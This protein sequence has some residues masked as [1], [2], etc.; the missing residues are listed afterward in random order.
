MAIFAWVVDILSKLS[1]RATAVHANSHATHARHNMQPLS[2]GG[3]RI[4]IQLPAVHREDFITSEWFLTTGFRV[5]GIFLSCTWLNPFDMFECITT[6]TSTT[7]TITT[8]L[9]KPPISGSPRRLRKTSARKPPVFGSP[10]LWKPL[11][12]GSPH[13]L[14]NLDSFS[15]QTLPEELHNSMSQIFQRLGASG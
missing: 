3:D 9:R 2:I 11:I 10:R 1:M 13:F 6:T 15:R 4:E 12:F 14:K 7:T 5:I 8:N